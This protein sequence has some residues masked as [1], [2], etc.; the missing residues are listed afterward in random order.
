MTYPLP[1]PE[2][3]EEEESLPERPE[4][5]RRRPPRRVERLEESHPEDA[6]GKR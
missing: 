6:E 1:K 4:E 3:K 2:E 5:E